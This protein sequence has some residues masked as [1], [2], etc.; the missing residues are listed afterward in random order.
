MAFTAYI[1]VLQEEC[2]GIDTRLAGLENITGIQLF[3]ISNAR[4]MCRIADHETISSDFSS[5]SYSPARTRVNEAMKNLK[6]FAEAF[7]CSRHSPMRPNKT[8]SFW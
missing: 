2:A 3:F 5:A 6:E 1:N 7:N 4:T 8:C